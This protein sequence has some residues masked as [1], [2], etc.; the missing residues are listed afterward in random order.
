MERLQITTITAQDISSALLVATYT[1]TAAKELL[2][3]LHLS[4]LAGGGAYRACL[5]RQ[6]AGAGAAY[7]S[8]TSV[9]AVSAGVTTAYL[10]TSPMPVNSGDV[11]KVYAQGLAA[12]TSVAG[13][14]EVFDVTSASTIAVSA[15]TASTV[16][17]G[18]A[19]ISRNYTWE[20]SFTST[21]TTNLGA[22]TKL[23]AVGKHKLSVADD[24]AEFFIEATAGLTRL[25]GAAYTTIANG[26]IT[27]T[28]SSGAWSVTCKLE[29]AVT[30]S[31]R[32][33]T[34]AKFAIKALVAGDTVDVWS[35][36]MNIVT[37]P[38]VA[39]S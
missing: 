36:S 27:V 18:T 25:A 3:N 19:S 1:A 29:E 4:G 32:E 7:Q 30:G 26:S 11:V 23:W 5:T 39:Y 24:D 6:I 16:A 34:A 12:D 31:L 14:V 33:L 2:I 21:T 38:I 15:A 28:G 35:G 9:V 10:A 20:Q 37:G 13:A 17:T 22:A 8:P